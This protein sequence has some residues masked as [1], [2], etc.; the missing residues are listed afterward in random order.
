MLGGITASGIGLA[1]NTV[2]VA[3]DPASRTGRQV[4]VVCVRTRRQKN[5]RSHRG[6]YNTR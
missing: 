5:K 3:G 4:C 6:G 1:G 2:E